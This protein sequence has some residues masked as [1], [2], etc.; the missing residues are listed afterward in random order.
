MAEP[1]LG[2]IDLSDRNCWTRYLPELNPNSPIGIRPLSWGE[3]ELNNRRGPVIERSML[4]TPEI[5][6]LFMLARDYYSGQ[7]EIVDLGPLLGV[8]TNALARGLEQNAATTNKDKRIHS[9]DLFLAKGMGPTITDCSRSGSVFDSFLRNNADYLN[10]I[11]VAPGNV[12]DMTWD[13]SPIEI[14]FIDLAKSWD[15]NGHVLRQFFSCLIPGRS[16]VIQQDYVH[17]AEYWIPITMEVLA[18][19]FD[20]LYFVTGTTSVYRCKKEIPNHLLYRNLKELSLAEKLRC[21][22]SARAK[23]PSSVGEILKCSQAYCLFEHGCPEDAHDLL[24][25]VETVVSATEPTPRTR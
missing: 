18:D 12:L 13:R 3:F 10:H 17:F 11:S 20:H 8:G 2:D 14:L 6:M 19:Y 9:F 24:K 15:L 25:T 4:A 7:G 22:E 23:A 5:T 1:E 21:L 16:I